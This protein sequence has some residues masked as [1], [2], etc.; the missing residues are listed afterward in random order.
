MAIL[1]TPF[2]IGKISGKLGNLVFRIR[3]NKTYVCRSPVSFTP[4]SDPASV[5]RRLR[6]KTTSGFS[7]TVLKLHY[8]KDVWQKI[9]KNMSAYNAIFKHNYSKVLP[10]DLSD[11]VSFFPGFGVE[12]ICDPLLIDEDGFIVKVKPAY[13][14]YPVDAKYIQMVSVLILKNPVYD[15]EPIIDFEDLNS[16]PVPVSDEMILKILYFDSIKEK[17][18][19]YGAHKLFVAFILLNKNK[20]FLHHSNTHRLK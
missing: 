5:D 20:E 14:D 4:A 13:P 1:R 2:P 8:V 11:V 3:N 10:D 17:Y 12:L 18:K 7:K 19:M 15:S 9:H 6:F 16:K